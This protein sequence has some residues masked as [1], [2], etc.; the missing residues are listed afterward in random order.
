MANETQNGKAILYGITNSGNPITI[1]GYASFILESAKAGHKFDMEH[2]K[3]ENGFDAALI[4]TNG[5]IE[6]DL[7][8]CP[9][10]ATRAAAIATAAMPAPLSKVTLSNFDVA[11]FNGD[12]VYVGDAMIDLTQKQAKMSLKIRKYDDATQN[13]SLVTTV[14]G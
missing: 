3:D 6:L 13:A 1:T 14:L 4:A 2:I 5:R 11:A 12:Y 10:G 7:T 9:A 8:W